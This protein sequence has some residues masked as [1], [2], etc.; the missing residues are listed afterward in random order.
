MAV[1]FLPSA[2]AQIQTVVAPIIDVGYID[3][4]GVDVGPASPQFRLSTSEVVIGQPESGGLAF[5]RHWIGSGWRD[6]L[7]GTISSASS[8]YT[9]SVGASSESFSLS[10]GIYTSLRA[11]GSTLTFN[12]GTNRYTYTT[13]DGTKIVFNKTIV[14]AGSVTSFWSSN[15]GAIETLTRPNGEVITYT[16]VSAT[17]GGVTAWRPQSASTNTNYQIHFTYAIGSPN[18]AGEVTGGYLQRTKVTGYNT[19]VF[20][21]AN[22]AHSCNDST[23]ANWPYVTYSTSGTLQTATDRLGNVSQ[24]NFAGGLLTGVRYPSS[25][26]ADNMTIAYSAGAVTAVTVAGQTWTYTPGCVPGPRGCGLPGQRQVTITSPTGGESEYRTFVASGHVFLFLE[27]KLGDR[28]L[29]FFRDGSGRVTRIERP[30][31]T[32]VEYVYD[33]RGNVTQ[34]TE[35]PKPLTGLNNIVTSAVF[36]AS[37]PAGEE[38]RCNQPS[39]TTDARGFRTDYTYSAAHG[40]VET[41]TLPNPAGAAPANNGTGPQ[42]RFTYGDANTG[43]LRVTAISSCS[44]G[45]APSCLGTATE[46][47]QVLSYDNQRRPISTTTRSGSFTVSQTSALT[48]TPQGDVATIDGPISG[49]GDTSWFY[50]DDLRRLRASV[51]PDPDAGGSL[52]HRVSRT[53]Y[54][55]ERVIAVEIGHVLAPSTWASMMTVVQ[56]SETGYDSVG[57]PNQ[58]TAWSNSPVFTGT[59]AISGFHRYAVSQVGYDPDH[60]LECTA[61]R[62]NPA[63]FDAAQLGPCSLDVVGSFGSDRISLSTYDANNGDGLVSRSAKGTAN[64]RDTVTRTFSAT[65]SL[66]ELMDAGNS[67]SGFEYDGFNRLVKT[68]FPGVSGA[69]NASDYE[70]LSYGNASNDRGVLI[71]KRGRDGQSFTYTYDNLGRVLTVTTPGAQPDITYTYDNSGRVLTASQPGHLITYAYDALSRLTSETQAGRMVS[72]LYDTGGRRQRLTWPDAVYVTYEYNTL[73]EMTAIRENG[74]TAL[75]TFA[76]DNLGRRTLLTRANGSYTQYAFDGASRLKD[77]DINLGGSANDLSTDLSYNPAGQIDARTTYNAAYNH[78][79]PSSYTDTYADNGLNQYTLIQST[80]G[81]SVTPTYTD[82][83]G[84]MTYDGTKTYIYDA[85]NRMTSAGSATFGYDPAS[86][87]YQAAGSATVRFLYDGVDIIGEYNTSGTLLRRYVHG[88]GVDE[89]LVWYEGAS[90]SDKRHLYADERGSIVAAEGATTTKNTYDEYGVPGA[91]N[92]GLFQYT[93]QIWI[94]DA[95]LYHY[96]ARTYNPELGR[97][98]Q[99]DPIGYA[100]G[101]NLYNYVGNDPF[102]ARDPFG[103]QECGPDC[104]VASCDKACVARLLERDRQRAQRQIDQAFKDIILLGWA[105]QIPYLAGR[106]AAD[107][108]AGAVDAGVQVAADAA[109]TAAIPFAQGLALSNLPGTSATELSGGGAI[110]YGGMGSLGVYYNSGTSEYSVAAKIAGVGGWGYQYN[111][112][113]SI[114]NGGVPTTGVN[115]IAS[116]EAGPVGLGMELGPNSAELSL[117]GGAGKSGLPLSTLKGVSAMAGAQ[118]TGSMSC[119]TLPK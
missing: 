90:T 70:Q 31:T 34:V 99:T 15:E 43:I 20:N 96:K 73:N 33:A 13:R 111:A 92:L 17:A 84:N 24:F 27:D 97:F 30:D 77:L 82:Q 7:A 94:A 37:C 50:Y 4:R 89:P 44:T 100:D 81:G 109:C 116:V 72:Y 10:G 51:S 67:R 78:P 23:G 93:G 117:G 14:T 36:P 1:V 87:L 53:T 11:R 107:A 86:R 79:A 88:P 52:Q 112:G 65:G 3:E 69:Q 46:T 57:R 101:M 62:M 40:G 49:A 29:R 48:Y 5:G 76:Y 118:L 9:V 63:R 19:A 64:E 61:F 59:T 28:R 58:Q 55:A 119:G 85:S 68:V 22:N 91:G 106:D 54:S 39:S 21:C 115:F 74:G 66:I 105:W 113:T 108:A 25:P 38:K 45:S 83:R 80:P 98:M 75:A 32:Y 114:S 26:S 12:A 60:R 71:S 6:S 2:W 104:I 95:G 102:N 103:L 42:I 41:V 8:I 56:K 18:N 35:A 110:G 16:Y 47:V